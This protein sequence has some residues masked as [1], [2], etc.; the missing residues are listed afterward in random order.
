[1]SAF[2]PGKLATTTLLA[3]AL[4]G[5]SLAP[6]H[7]QPEAS[8]PTAWPAPAPASQEVAI[9]LGLVDVVVDKVLLRMVEQALDNNRD[10]RQALLNVEA[11]R[12]QYGVRQADRFPTVGVEAGGTRQRTPVNASPSGAASTTSV[13][14]AGVGVTAFELDLFGRVRN[15]SESALQEYF[16]TE[17]NA[18]AARISLAAEV[19]Q[20]YVLRQSA[21]A[22]LEVTGR[23]FRAREASLQLTEQ[24][25]RA[26]AASALEYEDARGLTE[27]ARADLEQMQ[28]E[29]QQTDNA[30]RLLLG[31]SELDFM[32][33]AQAQTPLF[34][35]R[36]IGAGAPSD[37]INSRPDILAAENLLKARN[38]DIGAARAAFFPRLSLTALLGFTSPGLPELFRGSQRSWSFAPQLSLPIF[39]AGRNQ[40]NLDLA[41]VRKDM[42]VAQYEGSVQTAFREVAD[43]LAANDTLRREVD[44]R[45]ALFESS[46]RALTLSQARYRSGVDSNLKYLDAQRS[47]YA[48]ELAL[49]NTTAQ[50]QLAV[51]SLFK[52]LGGQ[53]YL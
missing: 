22:R 36:D 43:A 40:A 29:L 12:A 35:L 41:E 2:Q 3:L 23:T 27:Q 51:V 30:L 4:G 1:M 46:R 33:P 14:Q 8:I 24:R 16:A 11:A 32:P 17:H 10:L 20:T 15:L 31:T 45:Q 6:V 28:R 26:G 9:K 47:A 5:C 34:A 44:H 25:R 7:Q 39:D 38:A 19:M 49:I 18:R 13:Y 42:A 52:A 21:L 37:L 53:W 48:S 50:R